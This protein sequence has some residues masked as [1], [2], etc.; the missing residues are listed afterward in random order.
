MRGRFQPVQWRMETSTE[1]AATRLTAQPLDP[2]SMAI[3]AVANQGMDVGI[4]D[5]RVHACLIGT[6][7]PFR[8]HADGALPVGSSPRSKV[9]QETQ[10]SGSMSGKKSRSTRDNP[11]ASAA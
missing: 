11:G 2:F 9:V 10:V 4:T 5:P 6:G 8:L 7:K 1:R 3:Q